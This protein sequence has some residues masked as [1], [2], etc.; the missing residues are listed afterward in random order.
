MIITNECAVT[1]PKKYKRI[2][3]ILPSYRSTFV[4]LVQKQLRE[5]CL[6]HVDSSGKIL[7]EYSFKC[8]LEGL[9]MVKEYEA[10]ILEIAKDQVLVFNLKD[11][12]SYYQPHF[13]MST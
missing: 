11:Y 4:L 10:V 7:F 13:Y 9:A 8:A 2:Y 1:M 12:S 6:V 5:D 3:Q